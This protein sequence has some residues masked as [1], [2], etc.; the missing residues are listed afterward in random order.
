M[1]YVTAIKKFKK[2]RRRKRKKKKK[3]KKRKKKKKNRGQGP[4]LRQNSMATWDNMR[5]FSGYFVVPIILSHDSVFFP[6]VFFSLSPAV[7]YNKPLEISLLN[8]V[9][10]EVL[11]HNIT[12]ID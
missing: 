2:R 7:V 5:H 6:A 11:L 9:I 8:Y 4:I 12:V 10:N 1:A 3:E